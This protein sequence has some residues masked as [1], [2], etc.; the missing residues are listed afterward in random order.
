LISNSNVNSSYKKSQREGDKRVFVSLCGKCEAMVT[1]EESECCRELD[2]HWVFVENVTLHPGF[3]AC[4]LNP[5]VL[6]TAYILFNIMIL[7]YLNILFYF[8]YLFMSRHIRKT[9]PACVVSA[10]IRQ[11]P[12]ERGLYEGFL[13]T[14]L[15]TFN[16]LS[17][18]VSH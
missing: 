11:F 9:L 16:N 13:W 6:Q 8:I 15:K 18:W 1:A 17:V 7:K 5:Y 14:H 12:E 3:E 2:A 10:I 4:C